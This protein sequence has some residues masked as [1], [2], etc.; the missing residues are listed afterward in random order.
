VDFPTGAGAAVLLGAQSAAVAR[1]AS[2][3]GIDDDHDIGF[4]D[5]VVASRWAGSGV[6]HQDISA[7]IEVAALMCAPSPTWGGG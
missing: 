4:G 3:R 1:A 5:G 6:N 7:A 2:E